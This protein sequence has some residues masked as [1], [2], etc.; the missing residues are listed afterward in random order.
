MGRVVGS[1]HNTKG[2]LS[3]VIVRNSNRVT[4]GTITRSHEG[5]V[6]EERELSLSLLLEGDGATSARIIFTLSTIIVIN[7]VG[8]GDFT[9]LRSGTE[10]KAVADEFVIVIIGKAI[11][12]NGVTV[13]VI[14][15]VVVV[16]ILVV[17]VVIIMARIT[18]ALDTALAAVV[19]FIVITLTVAIIIIIAITII[20]TVAIMV[21]VFVVTLIVVVIIFFIIMFISVRGDEA[22]KVHRHGLTGVNG[23]TIITFTSKLGVGALNINFEK[24]TSASGRTTTIRT[25][26]TE[27]S[28][29]NLV[30][31]I[32]GITVAIPGS[33]VHTAL[34]VKLARA[35]E[36]VPGALRSNRLARIAESEVVV[37]LGNRCG[38]LGWGGS[39]P[40]DFDT[41]VVTGEGLDLLCDQINRDG[42]VDVYSDLNLSGGSRRR[43][44]DNDRN[45]ESSETRKVDDGRGSVGGIHKGDHLVPVVLGA[46]ARAE[47]VVGAIGVL[48]VIIVI[49]IVIVIVRSGALLAMVGFVVIIVM[50]IIIVVMVIFTA[51]VF[52][53]VGVM[54]LMTIPAIAI[55]AEL[56]DRRVTVIGIL[57]NT[58]LVVIGA[59]TVATRDMADV[60]LVVVGLRGG[61]TGRMKVLVAAIIVVEDAG[62]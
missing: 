6:G 8:E 49:V 21:V 7:V 38:V 31:D 19:V 16:I 1:A 60:N 18:R 17:I 11:S 57:H 4:I 43:S 39:H 5:D 53:E 25:T 41:K 15:I 54:T 13:V 33:E 14:A 62:H 47:A 24:S 40:H 36:E 10:H 32:D 35:G 29:T 52:T 50:I 34:V 30:A 56:A 3:A 58:F 51:V 27:T 59:L 45:L 48:M 23:S 37:R 9:G 42:L 26:R 55:D 20:V 2:N 22:R 46:V 28:I 44:G 12:T 61:I